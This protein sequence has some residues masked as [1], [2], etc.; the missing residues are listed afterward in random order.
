MP[1]MKKADLIKAMTELGET[2]PAKWTAREIE[3]R[4]AEL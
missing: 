2:P 4:L 3:C 1:T